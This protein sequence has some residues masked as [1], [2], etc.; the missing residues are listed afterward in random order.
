VQHARSFLVCQYRHW[1]AKAGQAP[2]YDLPD[3]IDVIKII[4]LVVLLVTIWCL[5]WS[6]A[7][8]VRLHQVRVGMFI[9]EM[10]GSSR[11][12]PRHS[13]RFL[14]TSAADIDSMLRGHAMSVIIDTHKGL[15]V[16]RDTRPPN[17]FDPARFEA[18]LN[19][20]FTAAEIA[21]ARKTINETKPHIRSVLSR[22]QIERV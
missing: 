5:D 6:N 10:E 9:E 14:V 15:D 12:L 11:P 17:V 19:T 16:D 2:D 3:A 7:K 21:L 8:R 18:Q 1:E 20:K 13:G 22:A 4:L